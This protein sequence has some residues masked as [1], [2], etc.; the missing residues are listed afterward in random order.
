MAFKVRPCRDLEEFGQAVFA[1]GQYFG[2]EPTEERMERFAKNLPI[3]R[4]HACREDGV[5]VGGAGAFPFELTVPGAVVPTAGVTVVG[6]FP[7]HRRRGVLRSMMRAQLDDVHAR[8]E[9]LALLWASEDTIYGRFGYG[10][11]SQCAEVSIPR[12]HS[13]FARPFEREGTV[14]LVDS[15]EA[16]KAL[17]PRLGRRPAKDAGHARPHAQLVGIPHPLRGSGRGRGRRPETPRRPRARGAARGLRDLPA[18]AEVDGGDL[19]LRAPGRR[20]RGARR[21]ADG[22]DLALPPRH[23][24]G[25]A[26][27][28]EPSARRPSAVVAARDAAQHAAARRRRPVGA[29]GRRRRGAVRTWHTRPTERS[30]S[31]SSTTSARGTRVAGGYRAGVRSGPPRRRSSAS[32]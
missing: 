13:A 8:G 28:G 18:Q 4:M 7:T 27:D 20:G 15:D 12:Q 6:T 9:P 23:R 24:L 32:T 5:T 10:M 16:L 11:A 14:R 22:R 30:S 1:I 21:P 26:N 3:E 2:M 25:R 19:R 17:P 31:T 29:A